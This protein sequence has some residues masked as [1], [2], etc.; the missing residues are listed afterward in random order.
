MAY[1][2]L[3]DTGAVAVY[4]LD[5]SYT[6]HDRVCT[7][8]VNNVQRATVSLGGGTTYGGS[9]T[10][11]SLNGACKIRC[12]ITAPSWTF[13]VDVSLVTWSWAISNGTA[14]HTQLQSA[15]SAL[16]SKGKLSDF[17]YE[18]WNDMVIKTNDLMQ[19]LNFAWIS[20]TASYSNTLMS[21][22]DK[23]LTAVRYNSLVAQINYLI[24]YSNTGAST[25]S[26]VGKG[27]TVYG[28]LF[29]TLVTRINQCIRA[30]A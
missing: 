21:S 11:T 20:S 4:G 10:L 15:Y 24:Y 17:S 19:Y 5:S 9:T 29:S 7:W 13:T 16:S 3:S 14:T 23:Q 1:I 6:V 28:S 25:L 22:G 8:Y 27:D 18:V 2:L 12:E 26:T 30:L